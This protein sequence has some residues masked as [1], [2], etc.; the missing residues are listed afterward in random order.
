MSVDE[1][2][3]DFVDRLRASGL[4]VSLAESKDALEAL[5]L[6]PLERTGTLRAAL[7]ATL[8]KKESDFPLFEAVFDEYFTGSLAMGMT[9]DDSAEERF[10]EEADY[11]MLGAADFAAMLREAVVS[12]TDDDMVALA[13]MAAE[14]IGMMEGGFGQ[15]SKAVAAMAGA[16][17]YVFR[18]MEWLDIRDTANRLEELAREGD[19]IPGMPPV[20][21]LDLVRESLKSFREALEREIRRRIALARGD[22][23]QEKKRKLPPR[24]EEID[25]TGATLGQVEEMRRVLPALAR[26][27][28]A[29]LARKHSLGRS[30]RV[31]FRSTMRH[32]LSYGGVPLDVRYRRKVPSKPEL[33]ILCDIS[34][35]VRTFSTFTLQ[36]VYSL[37]QQFRAVRSFAFIDRVD[38]VTDYFNSYDVDEAIE[39]VYREALVVDGDG[40]SDVGRALELFYQEY[41]DELS[42]K[43]SVL[44]LSDARNNSLDPRTWALESLRERVRRVY[45]LNPE[46]RDRWD[47]GDSIIAE[48]ID[49]C[50]SVHEC[51]NLKQLSDFV[52]RGA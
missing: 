14:G 25:F 11:A 31:D 6:V 10:A 48:Y 49:H 22:R 13:L 44:I 15:G 12:G 32:S 27:L 41:N 34:G 8:I 50:H 47:T 52:Y 39:Q 20:L 7:K 46:S 1:Q 18:A 26:R 2:L 16:G 33:F 37:H 28:A 4:S 23:E 19:L 38:E 29:R 24:P 9:G 35:S 40:H 5:R 3:L 30:G 17:Y 42:P 45:W 51:R 21:A 36:L 43:S